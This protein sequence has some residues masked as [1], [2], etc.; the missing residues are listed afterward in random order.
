MSGMPGL[1]RKIKDGGIGFDYRLGMG[2][3]DFWIKYLKEKKDEDWNIHELWS[4]MTNRRFGEKTVAYAESHD[5]AIV[6]DKTVAFWLMDKEMYYHM[7][8]DDQ[9][10][11]IDRELPTFRLCMRPF[12]NELLLPY[13]Y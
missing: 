8:V 7:Q 12:W 5:Q 10:L 9:N 2:I 11:L 4:V 3:P 1:C 6:G 13:Q